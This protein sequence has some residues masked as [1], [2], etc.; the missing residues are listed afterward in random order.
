MLTFGERLKK[1]RDRKGMR[2]TD[3]M[4]ATGISEPSLSRYESNTTHPTPEK[5]TRLIKLYDVSAEYIMGLTDKMG[6][7]V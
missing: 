6:H 2:Q 1:A 5:I 3:V 7:A 4:L